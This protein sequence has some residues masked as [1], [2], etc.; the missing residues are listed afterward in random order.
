MKSTILII[1]NEFEGDQTNTRVFIKPFPEKSFRSVESGK[2]SLS[3]FLRSEIVTIALADGK[4]SPTKIQLG[5]LEAHADMEEVEAFFAFAEK[6]NKRNTGNP[7]SRNTNF[8][9]W[10]C[11]YHDIIHDT[12][13]H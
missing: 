13:T 2:Q 1:L 5:K 10:A 8:G 12:T 7:C 6:I 11:D 9:E 4:D 3:T